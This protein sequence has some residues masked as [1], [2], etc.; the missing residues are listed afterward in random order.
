MVGTMVA[1]ILGA[2]LWR[3]F[4]NHFPHKEE[5]LLSDFPVLKQPDGISCGPT[6]AA[7]ALNYLGR[8]ATIEGLKSKAKT[9]WY[10]SGDTEI[11][12]TAPDVLAKAI[13]GKLKTGSLD[14]IK[15]HIDQNK[16]VIVLLRSGQ[17]TWHYVV[18][19]GYTED[20]ITMADPAGYIHSKENDM[21]LSAWNFSTDMSGNEVAESCPMCGGD[22]EIGIAA[23]EVCNEGRVDLILMAFILTEIKPYTMIIV[24]I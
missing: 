15:Y 21:F 19:I 2:V 17:T 10:K 13:P 16:P 14:E 6:S 11:G 4:R 12:M 23:C 8:E 18:V 3:D 20:N 9:T 7:M 22:G 5:N 1:I 24:S